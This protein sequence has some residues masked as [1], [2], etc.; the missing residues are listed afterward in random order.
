MSD[1]KIRGS[2][3]S[4]PKTTSASHTKLSEWHSKPASDV[5]KELNSSHHGLTPKE[6]LSRI[7]KFGYNEFK[8][9]KEP[10][11][12]IVFFRQFKSTI[13]FLLLAAAAISFLL[14]DILE[15]QIIIAILAINAII[16]TYHEFNAQNALSAL[17]KF[18]TQRV[19]VM[20]E[21]F[22]EII[23][24]REVVPGDVIVLR[25]GDKI[26]ADGRVFESAS[27]TI[28]ESVL[29]GESKAVRKITDPLK[30]K[31]A[32]ADRKN[33]LYSGT[34]VTSGR[35]LFVVTETNDN[36]E[37]GKIFLGITSEKELFPLQIKI[38]KFS[39]NLG[40]AS[41]AAVTLFIAV[42][43]FILGPEFS[44]GFETVLEL[45]IAQ[46][47]AFIPEGLPIVITIALAVGVSQMA[48]RNAITRKLQAIET[49][50]GVSI[51]CI[52]KTGTLTINKMSVQ[53]IVLSNKRYCISGDT[54]LECKGEKSKAIELPGI[55]PLI[56]TGLLCNDSSYDNLS[57]RRIGE[58]IEIAM[59]EYASKF[60]Y[61]KN[62]YNLSHPRAGEVQF[63]PKNKYMMT[64]NKDGENLKFHLKGA[65][66]VVLK[67][68]TSILI[69]GQKRRIISADNESI[70]KLTSKMA[71]EGLRVLAYAQKTEQK[72]MDSLTSGYTFTGLV[73]FRDPLRTD[74]AET[75]KRAEDAG[76]KVVMITGDHKLTAQSIAKQA[77]IISS[78]SDRVVEGFQIEQM[79]KTQ[80]AKIILNIK[81]FARV[82]GEHKSMIVD[83]FK[84]HGCIVAMTGDGVND[85]VALKDAHVG[86]SLGSGTDVAKEASDIVI[87]DD[88]IT[89]IVD[90]IEEGR[91]SSVNVRKVIKYLFA[92][93]VTEVLFLL[94][95]ILS[96]FWAGSLLPLALLP[97]H[98]LFVNLVTDGVLDVSLATEGKEKDLMKL[99]PKYFSGKLFSRDVVKF[100]AIS[101]IIMA[102]GMFVTYLFYLPFNIP[103]AHKQT[104][105]FTLL[106]FFQIWNSQNA[107][108]TTQSAFSLGIFKNKYLVAATI[109]SIAIQ[110]LVIYHPF[111][112]DYLKTMPLSLFDWA[113]IIGISS[114]I[115]IS[116][117]LLKFLHRRGIRTLA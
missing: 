50:G 106:A 87:T 21:G 86:V 45:A 82:T 24:A 46:A 65:P 109:I 38:N 22:E 83:G 54:Y 12:L 44:Y 31:L 52:D 10:S 64:A 25:A 70:S 18:Q 5:F 116:F 17:K 27:L 99:K 60:S 47:V 49:I 85:A 114:S 74:A 95:I 63:D 35:G 71:K 7:E 84:K 53:E 57:Q 67:F 89:S 9:T 105:F 107:R 94:A 117:E 23:D 96:P 15:A 91:R 78:A 11:I 69:E 62:K 2:T 56:E 36:T 101:S 97:I 48:K 73:G 40:K 111:F 29:T 26:A 30:G 113:I 88:K 33:M 43:A 61:D 68:C 39:S 80:L 19:N 16:G 81:V 20:R 28:D 92:T 51:L 104:I 58:P 66:E 93:D 3:H 98:I 1:P 79:G 34:F 100:I 37:I 6:A 112:N 8:E 41:I 103:L 110:L 32:L 102:L 75:I 72:K 4:S 108:S 42:F 13:V 115:F 14:G 59:T 77:G 90:A 55:L 76:I